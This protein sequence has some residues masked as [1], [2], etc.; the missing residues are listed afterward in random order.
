[1]SGG[2]NSMR[3]SHAS[4]RPVSGIS[5]KTGKSSGPFRYIRVYVKDWDQ[6]LSE[7][8]VRLPYREDSYLV[9]LGQESDFAEIYQLSSYPK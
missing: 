1:L 2:Y 7:L 8:R 9:K 4:S 3:T 5:K 6:Q